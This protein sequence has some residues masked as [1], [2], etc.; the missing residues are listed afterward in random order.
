MATPAN[1]ILWHIPLRRLG[2]QGVFTGRRVFMRLIK[3]D[4]LPPLLIRKARAKAQIA[5]R[6]PGGV[7]QVV[8]RR[9]KEVGEVGQLLELRGGGV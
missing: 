6:L 2:G 7:A 1:E 5:R 8:I 3:G 9:R 4:N